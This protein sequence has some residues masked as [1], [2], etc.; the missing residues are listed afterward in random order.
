MTFPR[1][2]SRDN[3]VTIAKRAKQYEELLLRALAIAVRRAKRQ[4]RDVREMVSGARVNGMV[5]NYK[6]M[7]ITYPNPKYNSTWHSSIS[8]GYLDEWTPEE[9]ADDIIDTVKENLRISKTKDPRD[10]VKNNS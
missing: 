4:P 7:S 5:P 8:W 10:T 1:I 3:P 6:A 9:L 2:T